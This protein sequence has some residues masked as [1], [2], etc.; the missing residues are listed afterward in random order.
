MKQIYIYAFIVIAVMAAFLAEASAQTPGSAPSS[1]VPV[2]Q[3]LDTIIECGE[4][5]LSHELYDA[6]ITL[7]ETIRG[8]EA[9]KRIQAADR[10]NP[11]AADGFEYALICVRFEYQARGLPGTCIHPLSPE[12]F[13]A[14]SANGEGYDNAAVVSPKPGL[15][16]QM[17][18]GETFE[19]YIVFTVAQ[20]DKAP[21]VYYSIDEGGGTQH[22]GG[23]WFV[24]RK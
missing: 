20:Q 23:K 8:E 2:G 1:P 13:T 18:S 17:K 11:P 14:Y 24:L 9:W 10:F 19:G 4:G 6:R 12:H 3:T 15:R 16:K 7:V 21:L 5:Y 22:G